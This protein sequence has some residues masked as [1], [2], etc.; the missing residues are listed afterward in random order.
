MLALRYCDSLAVA[1]TPCPSARSKSSTSAASAPRTA[2]WLWARFPASWP[3]A[4]WEIGLGILWRPRDLAPIQLNKTTRQQ[5]S[6]QCSQQ[7]FPS[8]FV[9]LCY[10]LLSFVIIFIPFVLYSCLGTLLSC[11]HINLPAQR[12]G[13]PVQVAG[14]SDDVP[15]AGAEGAEGR[16]LCVE[17]QLL[18]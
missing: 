16:G 4:S 18:G 8:P 11:C 2:S 1:K 13:V 12:P 14:R 6:Q 7:L 5:C 9:I 10:S 3:S 15:G 17:V